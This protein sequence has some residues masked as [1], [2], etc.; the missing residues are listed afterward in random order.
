MSLRASYA[1]MCVMGF[2][3]QNLVADRFES[4]LAKSMST[5]SLTMKTSL[6]HVPQHAWLANALS[7]AVLLWLVSP[8]MLRG[9]LAE[10]AN[11][12]GS[13]WVMLAAATLVIFF[14][15]RHTTAGWGKSTEEEECRV[16]VMRSALS[17]LRP[18]AWSSFYLHL[19]LSLFFIPAGLAQLK[20]MQDSADCQAMGGKG[21]KE[22]GGSIGGPGA[23]GGACLLLL[24]CVCSLYLASSSKGSMDVLAP[25]ASIAS[26]V[27]ISALL[28]RYLRPLRRLFS[29]SH[30]DKS[31]NNKHK[32]KLRQDA[33]QDEAGMAVVV[34]FG[35]LLCCLLVVWHATWVA[36]VHVGGG[37]ASGQGRLVVGASSLNGSKIILPDMF[38]ALHFIKQNTSTEA[39]IAAWSTSTHLPVLKPHL[40]LACWCIV[41]G[42][43]EILRLRVGATRH[44]KIEAIGQKSA[45]QS[46]LEIPCA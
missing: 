8:W 37:G 15:V 17:H 41:V 10:R 4:S 21:K 11:K 42:V 34:V 14:A 3:P 1:G 18:S 39:K 7:A 6:A 29:R 31:S 22:G 9:R 46:A 28:R 23:G 36:Y 26:A 19:H 35:A 30:K 27:A 25:F 2:L 33:L 13:A 32:N 45:Q 38:D 5:R 44:K 43:L 20:R 12:G 24:G 16:T 40:H